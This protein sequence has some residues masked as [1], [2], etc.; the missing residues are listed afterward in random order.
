MIN[1]VAPA[2]L[3]TLER[4]NDHETLLPSFVHSFIHSTCIFSH[5][6]ERGIEITRKTKLIWV[7]HDSTSNLHLVEQQQPFNNST[8]TSNSPTIELSC[9]SCKI[10]LSCKSSQRLNMIAQ[11]LCWVS[12]VCWRH[13]SFV[14]SFTVAEKRVLLSLHLHFVAEYK[15]SLLLLLLYLTY[16]IHMCL[17]KT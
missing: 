7:T 17:H 13:I 5:E 12:R 2:P 11:T 4:R 16:Y 9:T 10:E 6:K 14:P 8:R 15:I 1:L 3:S